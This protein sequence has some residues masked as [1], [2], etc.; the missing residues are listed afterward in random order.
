MT[1]DTAAPALAA[2]ADKDRHVPVNAARTPV[3]E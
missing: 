2:T 3:A 1:V